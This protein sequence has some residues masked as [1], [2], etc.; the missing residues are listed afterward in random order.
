V[1][2]TD[3]HDLAILNEDKKIPERVIEL[4]K[5]TG[6]NNPSI[7]IELDQLLD[8]FHILQFSFSDHY[9]LSY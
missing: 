4:A 9:V 7:G 5:G 8:L 3:A 2:G 1:V 6:K